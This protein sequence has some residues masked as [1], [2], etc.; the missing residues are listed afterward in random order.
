[1]TRE[2]E[3]RHEKIIERGKHFKLNDDTYAMAFRALHKMASFDMIISEILE[4]I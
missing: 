4:A 2:E 1:M 3:A